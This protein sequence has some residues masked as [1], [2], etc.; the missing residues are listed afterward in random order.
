MGWQ[1]KIKLLRFG[2]YEN[3]WPDHNDIVVGTGN[4][5]FFKS[6]LQQTSLAW[7]KR[8]YCFIDRCSFWR[9]RYHSIF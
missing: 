7:A 1:E 3:G 2:D 6:G 5:I 8:R 4:N 9:W